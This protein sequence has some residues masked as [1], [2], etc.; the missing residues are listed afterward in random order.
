MNDLSKQKI[1]TK[2]LVDRY[3]KPLFSR[4]NNFSAM[5]SFFSRKQKNIHTTVV[6]KKVHKIGLYGVKWP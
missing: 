5:T 4:P 6:C 2:Q 3:L 1:R